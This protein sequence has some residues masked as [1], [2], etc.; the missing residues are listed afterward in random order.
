MKN[1]ILMLSA[2]ATALAVAAPT[3]Q[4][5]AQD[6]EAS[7]GRDSI[8]VTAR[9][10]EENLLETPL[11]I[12][13]FGEEDIRDLG[14]QT[15]A[16]IQLF[17]PGF[18]FE[19]FATQPGRF[20]QSP[21]FRGIEVDSNNAFRQTASVFIDGL[22]IIRGASGI[23][24]S[25]VERVE[26]IKGPQSALFGRNSF[27]G[28]VNYISKTPGNEFAGDYSLSAATRD[29]YEGSLGIEGPLIGDVLKA[30]VSG[31]Y[32]FDGG[33]Y[34]NTAASGLG[35]ET[36]EQVTW[37]LAGS[38]FFEPSD[39]FSAKVRV[40]YFENHDGPSATAVIWNDEANCGP[41]GGSATRTFFCGTLPVNAPTQSTDKP[42]AFFDSLDTALPING[43]R[44]RYGLDRA[45]LTIGGSF[46]YDIVDNVTLS[47][48]LG[49]SKDNSTFIDDFDQTDGGPWTT[50]ADQEYEMNSQEVRL[51]GTLFDERLDWLVG[52]SR[53]DQEQLSAGAF[54]FGSG[55]RTN[56]EDIDLESVKTVG[57]FGSLSYEIVDG[58]TLTAEGRWQEDTVFEQGDINL[59]PLPSVEGKFTNFLPR[60]I[61]DYQV[62][63]DTLLYV[64]YAE[65]NNPGGFNNEV[66]ELSSADQAALAVFDPFAAAQFDEESLKNY[67]GGVKHAFANGKG[68]ISTAVFFMKR[69]G[70]QFRTSVSDPSFNSGATVT[71]FVNRGEA[72]I[73]G[74]EFEGNYQLTENFTAFGTVGYLDGEYTVIN[75]SVYN[76]YFGTTDASGQSVI[77]FPKWSAS[78]SGLYE[79]EV[80][81]TPAY[82]RADA[83]Y[84]GERDADIA[85]LAVADDGTILNLRA[86]VD[87]DS[88][89]FEIFALNVTDSDVFTGVGRSSGGSVASPN[90]FSQ[91]NWKTGLRDRRQFG[92]RITGSF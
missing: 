10:R 68:S 52:F 79:F 6:D 48:L 19:S 45:N 21:R 38:L 66:A 65:G 80:G 88:V 69:A 73:K 36:G 53:F 43:G 59:T 44:D 54:A 4:A 32:H 9:K 17:T 2:C 12:T 47:V 91:Y 18:V 25:D 27:G 55:P 14:L 90:G 67:E 64:T 16:D 84:I 83:S 49:Y 70:Q 30:R 92:A 20:D 26:V 15:I 57:V 37:S 7:S 56:V 50:L 46:D 23:N 63:D 71:Y 87:L 22:Y 41:F 11:A 28:A 31:Y 78:L 29:D 34:V 1:R 62:T 74:F 35:E 81:S 61:L 75:D 85:N 51:A 42:Q 58:L 5:I 33:H 40:G 13:A 60:F 24:L 39:N 77:R 72:E 89:R 82:L 86:G 8:V 76:N 3:T